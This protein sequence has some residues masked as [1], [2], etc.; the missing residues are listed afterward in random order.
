[1]SKSFNLGTARV[2]RE[3]SVEVG[4][5]PTPKKLQHKYRAK[6]CEHDG[7]KFHSSLEAA[8]YKKLVLAKSNGDVITFLRQVPFHLPGGVKYV[9][10]FLVFWENGDIE[11]VDTKGYETKDFKMKLKMVET[12]Y[13]PIKVTI[14]KRA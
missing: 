4:D 14:V 12:L 1:M 7:I 5:R 6:P 3:L 10:D 13:A 11:F 2:T 9:V 8:Y